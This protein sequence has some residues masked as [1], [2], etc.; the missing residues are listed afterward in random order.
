MVTR[1]DAGDRPR[2]TLTRP[3]SRPATPYKGDHR[4]GEYDDEDIH[5]KREN[6]VHRDTLTPVAPARTGRNVRTRRC[7]AIQSSAGSQNAPVRGSRPRWCA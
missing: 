2:L 1:Q 5:R 3:R 6:E 4:H 7:S